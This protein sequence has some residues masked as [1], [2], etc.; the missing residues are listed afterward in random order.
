MIKEFIKGYYEIKSPSMEV[1]NG[2]AEGLGLKREKYH[3]YPKAWKAGYAVRKG[4]KKLC[5]R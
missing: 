5:R 4:V 1:A 3:G 2:F